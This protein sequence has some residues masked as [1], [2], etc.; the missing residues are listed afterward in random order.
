MIALLRKF[1]G[2]VRVHRSVNLGENPT[3]ETERRLV[4]NWTHSIACGT[5]PAEPAPIR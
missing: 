3:K 1:S 2:I 4:V 5:T